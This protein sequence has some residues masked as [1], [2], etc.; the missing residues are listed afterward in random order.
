MRLSTVIAGGIVAA[1]CL[2]VGAVVEGGQVRVN[3]ANFAFSP[4]SVNLN[5]GD[6]VAWV[7]VS[8]THSVTQG[9]SCNPA[10]AIFDSGIGS[11]QHFAWKSDRTGSVPYF[12]QV[13]CLSGMTGLLN[14]SASG[15]PV[16]DFRLT[17]VRH[18]AAHTDDF[19]E[20]ANV[21]TAAGNLGLYRLSVAAGSAVVLPL[22]DIAVPVGGRVVVHLGLT[23]ANSATDI[24]L[25]AT[26]LPAN[27]SAALYMPNTVNT[28]L[29]AGDMMVD[30]V[31]WGAGGQPN[32]ATAV[33]E[34][35]W[36][37]GQFAPSM[38]DANS[39]EFCGL[40]SN[41]GAT[42]WLG[43][44]TPTPGSNGNCTTPVDPVSWGLVKSLYR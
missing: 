20:I 24:F 30:F 18:T 19:V 4:S 39:I 32:E 3:V 21:G 12:C 34:G 44:L 31:E 37:A 27:G 6:Q 2:G 41:R 29:T 42:F 15:T 16:S 35:F 33:T 8:G 25:P 36:T 11:G 26:T 10:G 7:W 13:H 14:I 40:E 23:G 38:L 1:L 43:I 9:T 28:N 22:T 17:E 5:Q